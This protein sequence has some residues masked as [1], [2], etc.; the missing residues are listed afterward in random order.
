MFAENF[1][2]KP[3]SGESGPEEQVSYLSLPFQPAGSP[4]GLSGHMVGVAQLAERLVVVQ[5]VAGSTPVA[6]P[7]E[8]RQ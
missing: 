5:E 3:K 4:E 6:H 8:G 1:D 2:E 7:H